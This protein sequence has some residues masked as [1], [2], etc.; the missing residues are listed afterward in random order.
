MKVLTSSKIKS[1]KKVKV[2]EPI[3][4]YDIEVPN[5]NNFTLSNGLVVHNSK[6]ILDTL[7][8]NV[9]KMNREYAPKITSNT[10][11]D[12]VMINASSGLDDDF[13][14]DGWII[15]EGITVI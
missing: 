7:A 14:Y 1:I 12:F 4:V 3:P 11:N 15:P 13:D 2:E 10:A 9:Y 8:A 5:Y 6:D